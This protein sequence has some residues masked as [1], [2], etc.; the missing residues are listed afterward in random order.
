M[1]HSVSLSVVYLLREPTGN[2]KSNDD[3]LGTRQI[4]S[5]FINDIKVAEFVLYCY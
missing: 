1:F 5:Y 2:G 3:D 4:M